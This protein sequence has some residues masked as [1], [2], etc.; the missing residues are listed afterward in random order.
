MA[1]PQYPHLFSPLEI[2]GRKLR[3]RIVA[4]PHDGPNGL[5]PGDGDYSNFSEHQAHYM[6]LLAR[7]GAAIVNTCHIGVDPRFR[8][9]G[10]RF[11]INLFAE[12]MHHHQL[13]M[14]HLMTDTTHAY[15]ALASIELNHG[16]HYN[17]PLVGN[18]IFGPMN[19]TMPN[20]LEVVEM[21]LAEMERVAEYFANA[22]ALAHKGGFDIVNVH[23]AHNWLFG[24]F[25]S[26][27]T[28]QRQDEFG[29]SV[30]NRAK[31][32]LM[33]LQYIRERIG[34]D[35]LISMRFSVAELMEGGITIEDAIKTINILSQYADIVHCSAGKVHNV[36]TSAFVFPTQ[37]TEH[38][39][40]AYLAAQVKQGVSIP[41]EAVGAINDPAMAEKLIANG[42]CDLVAM[43]RTFIADP[44]WGAKAKRCRSED[45]RP[46]I[47]C[48]RCISNN[49][50]KSGRMACTVNPE[51]MLYYS[52]KPS[53]LPA[54]KKKVTVVGGG[55]AGMLAAAELAAKGHDVVL[56]EKS[57]K[58]G[59][60]LHFADHVEFKDDIVRYREY[61][62]R[63]V[64]THRNID[65]RLSTE[66]TPDTVK[67]LAPD[68]VVVAIGAEPFVPPIPGADLPGAIH[69]MELFG[70]EDKLG[71]KV[72]II[73]G[74]MVGCE[75]AIHL[76]SMG[77]AVDIVEMAAELME[78]AKNQLPAEREATLFYVNHQY[79]RGHKSFM[80]IPELDT[81]RIFL[82]SRCVEVT[83]EGAVIEDEKGARQTLAGDTVIF[84]TGF[85]PNKALRDAYDE[86]A[87]DVI[88]IGD[89]KQV[90][91]IYTTSTSAYYAALQL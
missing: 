19:T 50:T 46:C 23:G 12:D 32:P 82:R 3:N 76:H 30:E 4:A 66:A 5:A 65:L 83:P 64:A 49:H 16:G 35:M 13:P 71:D 10:N 36:R 41:V 42:S 29:G 78:E 45:I 56:L 38:G 2:R 80:D 8:L 39:V 6:G 43:A 28:N 27:L 53:P 24:E 67:A 52:L 21:D 44:D 1:H 60:R 31:F 22:A 87:T 34:N 79:S 68:A 84:A 14:F 54:E 40:N 74:G 90:G 57:E 88:D 33:I 72:I 69:A 18:K 51:R 48:L 59:G 25:V 81:V 7:G 20:G 55:P 73:G 9:G 85:K 70:N 37:Y 91:S 63:Q 62:T 15:G 77:K 47:R 17:T 61:L 11:F 58:L 75:A 89:C 86:I 26:P